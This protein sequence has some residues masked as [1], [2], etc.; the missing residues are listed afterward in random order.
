MDARTHARTRAHTH[1]HTHTHVMREF[2]FRTGKQVA[3]LLEN[4]LNLILASSIF[5]VSEI[6]LY[7]R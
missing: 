5:D 4:A 1:T 7:E 3:I 6:I 2:Y